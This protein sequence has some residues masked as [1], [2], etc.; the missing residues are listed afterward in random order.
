MVVIMVIIFVNY[1]FIFLYLH[2]QSISFYL[3]FIKFAITF[4]SIII[5]C[6]IISINQ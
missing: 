3:Q 5:K 1:N 6:L 4:T 2:F